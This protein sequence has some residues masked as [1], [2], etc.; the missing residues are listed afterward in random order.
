M[1]KLSLLALVLALSACTPQKPAPIAPPVEQAAPS[2]GEVNITLN[3]ESMAYIDGNQEL[4]RAALSDIL[5]GE[6][7]Y[8]QCN[9]ISQLQA[10]IESRSERLVQEKW[11][12]QACGAVHQY[13]VQFTPGENGPNYSI[14]L[15]Q[16]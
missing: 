11:L 2:Q 1:K 9:N 3:G 13:N 12:I 10:S 5:N 16:S 4:L 14:T 8:F 6:Q 15:P 7:R